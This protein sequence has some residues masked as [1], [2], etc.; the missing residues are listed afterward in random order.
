M[1]EQ[2]M[3]VRAIPMLVAA[4]FSGYAGAA[5]FQLLEQNASGLGNSYAGSAAMDSV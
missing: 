2:R 1:N 3:M 4:A 5:G